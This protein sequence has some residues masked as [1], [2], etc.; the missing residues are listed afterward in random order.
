MALLQERP[1]EAQVA[2]G[3]PRSL[4]RLEVESQIFVGVS[5]LSQEPT[6]PAFDGLRP[7]A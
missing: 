6:S 5:D 2:V 3:L 4:N 1:P 7:S